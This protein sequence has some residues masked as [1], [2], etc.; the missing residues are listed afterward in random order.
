MSSES[1]CLAPKILLARATLAPSK[2][3][4]FSAFDSYSARRS[5]AVSSDW[6]WQKVKFALDPY[7]FRGSSWEYEKKGNDCW[8]MECTR[9]EY[10]HPGHYCTRRA[11]SIRLILS[12]N[13]VLLRALCSPVPVA[14]STL[15]CR[16]IRR[17]HC[18]GKL[19]FQMDSCHNTPYASS[20]GKPIC[21]LSTDACE[22]RSVCA[23]FLSTKSCLVGNLQTAWALSG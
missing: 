12:T 22:D 7:L 3:S 9:Q 21:S 6:C 4:A 17:Q 23:R 20:T 5:D 1:L 15:R 16:Q 2:C 13:C 10:S 19:D 11:S 14:C 8:F 18:Q